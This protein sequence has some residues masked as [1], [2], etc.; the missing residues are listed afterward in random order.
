MKNFLIG[1]LLVSPLLAQEI[2]VTETVHN[3]SVSGHGKIHSIDETEICIGEST[4]RYR[5]VRLCARAVMR[6]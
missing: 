6:R 2:S 4:I 3:L 5:V 1:L